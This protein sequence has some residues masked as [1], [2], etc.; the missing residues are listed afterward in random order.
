MPRETPPLPPQIKPPRLR[1]AREEVGGGGGEWQTLGAPGC[2]CRTHCRTQRRV[3]SEGLARALKTILQNGKRTEG[4]RLE[5][6]W[7]G[8]EENLHVSTENPLSAPKEALV[9]SGLEVQRLQIR[10]QNP[11]TR[12]STSQLRVKPFNRAMWET[13]APGRTKK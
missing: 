10:P 4:A 8:G 5:C 3:S 13:T 1:G 2:A 6:V 9:G 12:P 11:G 7:E